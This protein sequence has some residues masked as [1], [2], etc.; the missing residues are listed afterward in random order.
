MQRLLVPALFLFFMVLAVAAP[1]TTSA[2]SAA[3]P[4]DADVQ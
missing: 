2:V 3:V 4:A 1:L